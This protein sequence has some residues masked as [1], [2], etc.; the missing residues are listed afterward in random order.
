MKTMMPFWRKSAYFAGW[1]L[2][3]AITALSLVPAA[4]RPET[5]IPHS[6]EHF[7]IFWLTGF[8]FGFAYD[9]WPIVIMIALVMFSGA[10]E[11]AQRFVPDRHARISDFIVDALGA[12]IGATI[13]LVIARAAARKL[14]KHENRRGFGRV[15]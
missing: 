4:L 14:D 11:L 5:N 7:A 13:A 12:C 2:I 6:L 3:V 9:R 1:L 10:V 8:A 15:D